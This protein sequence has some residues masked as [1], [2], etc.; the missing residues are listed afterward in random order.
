MHYVGEDGE[1]YVMVMDLLGPSLEDLFNY[2]TR[3]FSVKT[4]LMIA[5]QLVKLD[6]KKKKRKES[7][8]N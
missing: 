3:R 6:L 7:S 5:D 1:Y 4:V 8:F 2:C